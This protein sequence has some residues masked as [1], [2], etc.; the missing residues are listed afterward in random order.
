MKLRF[1]CDA[2]GNADDVY[3]DDITV[4]ASTAVTS[5]PIKQLTIEETG[6]DLS[7]DLM[8]EFMVY[9]NPANEVLYVSS[10]GDEVIEIIIYDVKGQIVQKVS[11][12]AGSDEID[13]SKLDKGIYLINIQVD[14]EVF[15]KKII[16][17]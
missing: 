13:I 14:D 17:N 4:T 7:A 10:A 6:R 12:P 3:I 5:G 9:P 11:L 16:K 2:S 1:M 15:T 8:D